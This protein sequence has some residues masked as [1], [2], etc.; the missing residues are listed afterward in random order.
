M[1]Q[2]KEGLS[3]MQLV[4]E[5]FDDLVLL[6]LGFQSLK[7]FVRLKPFLHGA[8]FFK[9]ISKHIHLDDQA[10]DTGDE[11]LL[12]IVLAIVHLVSNNLSLLDKAIPLLVKLVFVIA[13]VFIHDI[14]EVSFKEF[15]HLVN[16]SHLVREI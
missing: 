5:H 1:G 7:S 11:N 15:V 2:A 12:E 14:D 8:I 6:S 4:I 9:S 3:S 10:S 13:L 16:G